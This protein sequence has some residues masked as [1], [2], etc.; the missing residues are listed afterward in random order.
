[1]L[2]G[3]EADPERILTNREILAS[4]SIPKSIVIIGAGAVGVEFASV[5]RCALAPLE[6]PA[7]GGAAA[8]GV[9]LLMG[10]TLQKRQFLVQLSP[11]IMNV[12]FLLLK[13]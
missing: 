7:A 6:V 11:K 1:M 8:S 13:Q 3:L 4:K 12:T 2:P 9:L 10:L 5:Y